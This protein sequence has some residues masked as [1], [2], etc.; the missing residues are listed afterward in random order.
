M[1]CSSLSHSDPACFSRLD[2]PA[3]ILAFF[4]TLRLIP[5]L[6]VTAAEGF[7]LVTSILL[8]FYF[9]FDAREDDHYFV[10]H[11]MWHV[12]IV[13]GQSMVASRVPVSKP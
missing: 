7:A 1:T 6:Q 5:I 10:S 13:V 2:R 12:M 8:A 11:T 9:Y 3:A 4:S